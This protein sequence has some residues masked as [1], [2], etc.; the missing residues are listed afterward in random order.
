[1]LKRKIITPAAAQVLTLEAVKHHLKVDTD[2]DDALI[3]GIM[4]AVRL[5]AEEHLGRFLLPTV[6]EQYYNSFAQG[7]LTLFYTPVV[8][9]A[10]VKYFDT[11][12]DEQTLAVEQ[13]EIDVT[14]EPSYMMIGFDKDV[15]PVRSYPNSVIIRY[16]AGYANAAAVPEPIKQAMLLMITRYYEHRDDSVFRMPTTAHYLLNP[17]RIQWLW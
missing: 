8:E 12:G 6:L 5:H 15:P 1:M 10:S 7:A 13:Y 17:Y 4:T 9:V 11:N 16:T 2:A 14:Q 3:T